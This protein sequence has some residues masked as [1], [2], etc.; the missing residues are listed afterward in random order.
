MF[1]S[2]N[3][4]STSQRTLTDDDVAA[5]CAIYPPG[6]ARACNVEPRGGFGESC[7]EPESGG[8]CAASP[9]RP[10]TSAPGLAGF[11]LFGLFAVAVAR[12]RRRLVVPGGKP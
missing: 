8:I 4:G 1:A 7:E 11:A 2:Y 3:P 5:V 10:A 6:S 9:A 12:G